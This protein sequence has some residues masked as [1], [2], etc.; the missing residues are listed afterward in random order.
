MWYKESVFYQIYPLGLCGAPRENDGQV[1]S[2]S[3][4][5]WTGCLS[6]EMNIN[7]VI[8]ILFDSDRHGYDTRNSHK[9][10]PRLGT[11]EDL[12]TICKTYNDAGLALM[13][14]SSLITLAALGLFKM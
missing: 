10:D 12:K 11:N 4:S 1:V 7:G 6:T 9:L 5:C 8:L 14:D 3:C 13:F 2:R